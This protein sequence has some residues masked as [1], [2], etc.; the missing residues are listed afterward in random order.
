MLIMLFFVIFCKKDRLRNSAFICTLLCALLMA[1]GPVLLGSDYWTAGRVA[2][3][4]LQLVSELPVFF[5]T[6]I[7]SH[8]LCSV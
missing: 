4:L 7:F 3:V 8:S 1:L 2:V 6:R 5:C